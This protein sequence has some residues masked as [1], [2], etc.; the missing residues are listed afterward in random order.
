M[1][2][3]KFDHDRNVVSNHARTVR[4]HF[5]EHFRARWKLRVRRCRCGATGRVVKAQTAVLYI[6][7]AAAAPTTRELLIPK[8]ADDDD[9]DITPNI[10]Q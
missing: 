4:R 3:V 5:R 8:E 2:V 9:D 1:N 7:A 6:A 10:M